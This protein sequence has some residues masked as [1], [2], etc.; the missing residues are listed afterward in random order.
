MFEKFRKSW[1][2]VEESVA[3][4]SQDRVLLVFPL[5]SLGAAAAFLACLVI[6]L[7]V[8]AA[9]DQ[10]LFGNIRPPFVA[11][12]MFGVYF[13]LSFIS[14]FFGVCSVHSVKSTLAGHPPRLGESMAFAL[15]KAGS[16]ALWALISATVSILLRWVESLARSKG[17]WFG[18]LLLWASASVFGM[19]WS[20]A[21]LFVVQGMVYKDLDPIDAVKDSVLVMKKTWGENLAQSLSLGAAEFALFLAGIPA[22]LVLLSLASRAGSIALAVA[23]ALVALALFAV[24]LFFSTIKSVFHTVLYAYALE[25][26][27]RGGFS[28]KLLESAFTP[29]A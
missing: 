1:M 6:P 23:V 18:K 12:G 16:I 21:T 27:T 11:C 20:L 29:Q 9:A 4:L 13:G 17:G 2:L 5:L 24:V 14:T 26:K 15:G 19:A 10:A 7:A 8:G 22:A 25:G 28:Q 3:I